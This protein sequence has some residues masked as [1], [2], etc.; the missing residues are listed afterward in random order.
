MRQ[1][2][3]LSVAKETILKQN[4]LTKKLNNCHAGTIKQA[5]CW[6]WDSLTVL[7]VQT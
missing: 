2:Q 5:K 7:K 1:Q 4:L 3:G 6:E